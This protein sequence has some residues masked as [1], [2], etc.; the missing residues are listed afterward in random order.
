MAEQL[1][2]D[3]FDVPSKPT[4]RLFFAILPDAQIAPRMVETAVRLRRDQ[5]LTGRPSDVDRLHVTL[6]HLGDHLEL[7]QDIVAAACAAA[8]SVVSPPFDITFDRAGSFA[9]RNGNQPFVLRGSDEGLAGVG[10]LQKTLADAMRQVGLGR[11]VDVRFT[12]HVTLLYDSRMA[13]EQ[14]VEPIT[15][16]CR[17]FVLVHSRIGQ[18]RHA[19]LARWTLQ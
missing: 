13:A 8:A 12:P 18:H 7:R 2:L 17:E 14:A 11:W 5:G 10:S 15:W 3:G 4:D 1:S 9:T 6:H 16:S 19:H